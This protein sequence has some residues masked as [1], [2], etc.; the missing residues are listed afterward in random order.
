MIARLL[1]APLAA[2]VLALGGCAAFGG[3]DAPRAAQSQAGIGVNA[4]LWRASL[5][6]LD[7]MPLA[8]VDPWGGVIITDWY[9][10]P[11]TP[12]ERFRAN[13][14]ILDTRLRAD[15]LKL[16]LFRQERVGGEWRDASTDP[17]TT[18]Q[19]E[20]AIL[21]RARQLRIAEVQG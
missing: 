18:T 1:V 7:F 21:T 4:L 17:A 5:D 8:S 11:A 12:D 19:L 10:D 9:A 16:S 2:S 20:N 3:G 15:A 13:V 6:T 14:F